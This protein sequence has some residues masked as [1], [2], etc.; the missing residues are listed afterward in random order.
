MF[1]KIS[2]RNIITMTWTFVNFY[3]A[4]NALY[5]GKINRRFEIPYKEH[6][7]K[8]KLKTNPL[9]D[10]VEHVPDINRSINISFVKL[11][12]DLAIVKQIFRIN[13]GF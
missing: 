13:S 4:V 9:S 8:M 5:F 10:F 2:T 11:K 7:S 1:T 6:C 3:V 12:K